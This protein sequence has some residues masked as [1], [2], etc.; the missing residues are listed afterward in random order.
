MVVVRSTGFPDNPKMGRGPVAQQAHGRGRPA[1]VVED[2]DWRTMLVFERFR[3]QHGA[4]ASFMAWQCR[5]APSPAS[6]R[7]GRS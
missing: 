5:P 6:T 2:S 1:V 4:A 7:Y 3:K